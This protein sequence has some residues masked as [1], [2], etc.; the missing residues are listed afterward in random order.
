MVNIKRKHVFCKKHVFSHSKK[1]GCKICKVDID[2]Y[3][4][5]SKYMQD[6]I[7][8]NFHNN[9]TEKIKKKFTNHDLKEICTNILNNS[10]DKK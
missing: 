7:F 5:S 3:D 1:S 10:T 9:L 4:T 2:N 6:K 8:K